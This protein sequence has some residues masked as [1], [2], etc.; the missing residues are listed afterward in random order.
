MQ[1]SCVY[2]CVLFLLLHHTLSC[3]YMSRCVCMKA[4]PLLKP[5]CH[6]SEGATCQAK[7]LGLC[8]TP[9]VVRPC[10]AVADQVQ[11]V[12]PVGHLGA[13]FCHAALGQPVSMC[14]LAGNVSKRRQTC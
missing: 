10:C 9:V 5:S 14:V 11:A 7:G 3:V 6:S 4:L 13:G 1:V 2:V 12:V 8:C